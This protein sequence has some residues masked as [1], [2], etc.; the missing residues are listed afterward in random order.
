MAQT[1][2]PA[3]SVGDQGSIPGTGRSPGEGNGNPLEYSCLENSMDG[4][5]WQATVHGSQRA[6]H[7]WATSLSLS[8]CP[9]IYLTPFPLMARSKI[10]GSIIWPTLE[11]SELRYTVSGFQEWRQ[12]SW[13]KDPEALKRKQV[14][15]PYWI[16]VTNLWKTI[17]HLFIKIHT[18]NQKWCGYDFFLIILNTEK[19]RQPF[20]DRK[21]H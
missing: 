16:Q 8:F 18:G 14:H 13:E 5:A 12:R 3:R 19:Q 11:L 6:G 17:S 15:P 7:D 20:C 4:G 10:K 2:E 1:V 9:S 21:E